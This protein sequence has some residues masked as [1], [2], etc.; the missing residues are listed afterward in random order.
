MSRSQKIIFAP[1]WEPSH[2]DTV[3]DFS[4]SGLGIQFVLSG[5]EGSAAFVVDTKWRLPF[6]Q[7]QI[8][9]AIVAG[10]KAD[11]LDLGILQASY[12]PIAA[13][14]G[15]HSIRPIRPTLSSH[16]CKWT[17]GDCYFYGSSYHRSK[18]LLETLRLAGSDAVWKLLDEFY[19]QTVVE[20]TGIAH[21]S[22]VGREVEPCS[23]IG[24][25]EHAQF[26]FCGI[27][28]CAKHANT[29]QIQGHR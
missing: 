26:R 6:A 11:H 17:G 2:R 21:P 7:E 13:E 23:V 28:V 9:L 15:F 18:R 5:S 3:I 25:G 20:E 19:T 12:Q 8:D 4:A 24:C 1:A 16:A 29:I 10:A 22:R 14:L 27:W